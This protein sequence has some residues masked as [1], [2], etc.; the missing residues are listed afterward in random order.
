MLLLM[1]LV[2]LV[3]P[4]RHNWWLIPFCAS[5]LSFLTLHRL[6]MG[7]READKNGDG[8]L[9]LQE[10]KDLV[11]TSDY[12]RD[13]FHTILPSNE[14]FEDVIEAFLEWFWI[15][16]DVDEDGRITF[17]ELKVGLEKLKSGEFSKK[18]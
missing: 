18:C 17:E 1:S 11:F 7:Y 8:T 6:R 10:I 16:C 4:S 5:L 13:N 2:L 15:I 9:D 12:F 14:S 3:A